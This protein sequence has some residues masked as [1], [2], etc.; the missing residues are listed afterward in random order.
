MEL[1]I[2]QKKFKNSQ[3][4]TYRKQA[5][6]SVM[7]EYFCIG[8]IDFMLNSKSLLEYNNLFFSN[9]YEMNYKIIFS[10][11]SKKVKMKKIF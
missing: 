9:K 7:F 3:E 1:N 10:I 6:D 5:Y 8:F 4:N 2:F 11:D